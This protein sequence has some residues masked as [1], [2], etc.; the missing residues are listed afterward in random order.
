MYIFKPRFVKKRIG[1]VNTYIRNKYI[2]DDVTKT[3]FI[4]SSF[5]FS[6]FNHSFKD[7]TITYKYTTSGFDKDYNYIEITGFRNITFNFTLNYWENGN[8]YNQTTRII[9]RNLINRTK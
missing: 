8:C 4:D 6:V 7:Y 9:D 5:E 2:V 3:I 1:K